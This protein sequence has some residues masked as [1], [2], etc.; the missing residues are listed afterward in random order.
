MFLPLDVPNRHSRQDSSSSGDSGVYFTGGSSNVQQPSSSQSC[1]VV[2]HF[3]RGPFDLEEVKEM[4]KMAPGRKSQLLIA[5]E[6]ILDMCVWGEKTPVSPYEKSMKQGRWV[7]GKCTVCL[8]STCHCETRRGR[9]CVKTQVTNS[10]PELILTSMV[11]G[12]CHAED[13]PLQC[14]HICL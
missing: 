5:D 8:F 7:F 2:K 14:W 10:H 13:K 6:G 4:Q 3:R 9:D 11:E 12:C 1:T